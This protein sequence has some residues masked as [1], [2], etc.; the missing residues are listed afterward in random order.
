MKAVH[1]PCRAYVGVHAPDIS[2]PT[3]AR[4]RKSQQARAISH[5]STEPSCSG[6]QHSTAA[7]SLSLGRRQTMIGLAASTA[8]LGIPRAN[9]VIITPPPGE[10]QAISGCGSA[11]NDACSAW[12]NPFTGQPSLTRQ[13][14][15]P[16]GFRVHQDKL[17]GYYFFFPDNWLPVTVSCCGL[18]TTC[19]RFAVAMVNKPVCQY[20]MKGPYQVFKGC[21]HFSA[22][23]RQ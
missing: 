17:D 3:P 2:A 16:A 8:L 10:I 13:A 1:Q 12:Q 19:C 6:R 5:C 18:L 4:L 15:W 20:C 7:D 21:A 11:P 9:A 22:D 23:I 14:S